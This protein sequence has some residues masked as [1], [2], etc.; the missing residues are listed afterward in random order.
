VRLLR[1][2]KNRRGL[3][4]RRVKAKLFGQTRGSKRAVFV[5]AAFRIFLQREFFHFTRSPNYRV[6]V[7][8]TVRGAFCVFVC[9][10]F[11]SEIPLRNLARFARDKRPFAFRKSR[12]G[13]CFGF[14]IRNCII[15]S[16]RRREKQYSCLAI[17]LLLLIPRSGLN[18]S[19]SCAIAEKFSTS[20][21]LLRF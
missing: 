9:V 11:L 15:G 19:D 7:P 8:R 2:R 5:A 6:I 1:A 14:C 10:S 20:I 4:V 13:F 16:D 17:A 3:I 12:H 18:S 21:S